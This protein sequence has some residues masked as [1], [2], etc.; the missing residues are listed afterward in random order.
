MLFFFEVITRFKNKLFF[1]AVMETMF[2]DAEIEADIKGCVEKAISKLGESVGLLTTAQ[3]LSKVDEAKKILEE[4]G[5]KV[6]V[7]VNK[8]THNKAEVLGCEFSAAKEIKDKVDSYLYIGT[9][10]FHPLGVF[11]NLRKK[12]ICADPVSND[13]KEINEKDVEVMEK[14]KKGALLKF[15][16][17]KNIGVLVTTKPGQDRLKDALKLKDEL[18]DKNVYVFIDNTFNF[19]ELENFPFIECYVNT[20]CPRIGLDDSI[21]VEKPIVNIEDIRHQVG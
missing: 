11:M 7:G 21:R 15:L 16:T 14:R 13:V 12:V 6:F 19:N 2:V 5:K 4:N 3:H 1:C 20:M 18:V 17:S 10:R 9:G 8:K